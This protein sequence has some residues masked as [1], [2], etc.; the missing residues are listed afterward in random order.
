MTVICYSQLK[1]IISTISVKPNKRAF[2]EIQCK[3]LLKNPQSDYSIGKPKR[4]LNIFAQSP[5]AGSS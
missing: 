4:Q 3:S 2:V 5:R 1:P